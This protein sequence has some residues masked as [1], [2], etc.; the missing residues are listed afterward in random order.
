VDAEAKTWPGVQ[1]L[2]F[3]RLIGTIW[4]T[5]DKKHAVVTPTRLLMGAYLGLCRVRDLKDMAS[6]LFLCTLF[7][8]FEVLSKR[9][10][11]EA[12]NFVAN[13]VLHMAPHRF[14]LGGQGDKDARAGGDDVDGTA[15]RLPLPGCFPCP[16]LGAD[17]CK[18]LKLNLAKSQGLTI[19]KPDLVGA[20]L[21]QRAQDGD[22]EQIKV[23]LL[24]LALELV[25][26]FADMYK[27][28][29]GFIELYEPIQAVLEGVEAAKMPAAY[30]VK[31]DLTFSLSARLLLFLLI[32]AWLYGTGTIGICGG[33]SNPSAQIFAPS[34]EATAVTRAQADSD[35]EL[36]S[37]VRD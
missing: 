22:D 23:D 34:P 33:H 26:R 21:Q 28:L 7:L 4:P 13:A 29:D 3:L 6:G 37:Q 11:P 30:Q 5:S 18:S 20:L 2:C 24:G 10:V 8:Q 9:L 25:G 12:V 15:A 1:E 36:C 17:R 31:K 27:G 19:G 35:S 32:R 14:R 16:D